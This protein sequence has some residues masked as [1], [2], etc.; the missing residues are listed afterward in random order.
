M[1]FVCDN[2]KGG[3]IA[4][5]SLP[6]DVNFGFTLHSEYLQSL[7]FQPP[8]YQVNRILSAV[9]FI[10]VNSRLFAKFRLNAFASKRHTCN[11]RVHHQIYQL[12][13]NFACSMIQF[14]LPDA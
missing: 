3:A 10:K 12:T 4:K 9:R 5:V 1:H 7:S 2:L 13:Q 6:E 14:H 11:R 8:P